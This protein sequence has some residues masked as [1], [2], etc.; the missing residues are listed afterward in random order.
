VF[1]TLIG[2]MDMSVR[3]SCPFRMSNHLW[4][5]NLITLLWGRDVIKDEIGGKIPSGRPFRPDVRGRRPDVR[6]RPR[7]PRGHGFT[8]G[9]VFIVRGRSKNRVRTDA[10]QRPHGRSCASARTRKKKKKKKFFFGSFWKERGFFQLSIFGFRFSI[11]KIPKIPKLRG[12]RGRSR[13]KK[14]VFSA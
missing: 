10:A 3:P 11:P 7:L 12:L 1:P 14:K 9:R 5:S 8:R 6:A 4:T 13:E 2:Q